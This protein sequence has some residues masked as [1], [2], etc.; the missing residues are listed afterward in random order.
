MLPFFS[1]SISK[2]I[3]VLHIYLQVPCSRGFQNREAKMFNCRKLGLLV[4]AS[5]LALAFVFKPAAVRAEFPSF[6]TKI[7][8]IFEKH[9][10]ECHRPGGTGYE[11]SGLDMRTYASLMKG[12]KHGPVVNPGDAFTSNLMVLIEG[13]ADSSLKMP[14]SERRDLSRWEKQLIRGWINGGAKNN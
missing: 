1:V 4:A 13:R 2:E 14:H 12:T 11:I 5:I 8:P 7:Y 3:S 6:E 10:L 9:C